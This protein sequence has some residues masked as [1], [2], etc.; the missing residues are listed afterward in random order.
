MEFLLLA[1]VGLVIDTVVKVGY[2]FAGSYIVRIGFKY[3]QD[4]K[5]SVANEKG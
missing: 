5:E 2:A 4:Y 3:V 1:K